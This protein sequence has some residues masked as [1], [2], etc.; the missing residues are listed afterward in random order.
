MYFSVSIFVPVP[1]HTG[2]RMHNVLRSSPSPRPHW[3]AGAQCSQIVHSFI[4]LS[5]VHLFVSYQCCEQDT[6]NGLRCHTRPNIDLETWRRHHSPLP[7]VEYVFLVAACSVCSS[8]GHIHVS[9]RNKQTDAQTCLPSDAPQFR[10]KHCRKFWRGL[11]N[12]GVKC[13]WDMKIQPV[14]CFILETIQDRAILTV[15]LQ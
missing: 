11:L 3:Q 8:V 10:T 6:L 14:S 7:W 1:G 4:Y 12:G 13:R 2:R 15:E 9:C 5:S